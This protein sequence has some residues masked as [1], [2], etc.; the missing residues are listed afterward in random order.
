MSETAIRIVERPAVT[1]INTQ[2]SLMVIERRGVYN[3]MRPAIESSD[4]TFNVILLITLFA[5]NRDPISR[6]NIAAFA[7][8]APFLLFVH[9][10]AAIAFVQMFYVDSAAGASYGPLARR[11]WSSVPYFYG[12]IGVYGSAVALWWLFRPSDLPAEGLS[13]SGRKLRVQRARG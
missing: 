5:I 12:I 2:G 6:R 9:V 10:A 7:R 3:T 4:L 1:S 8:A 11:F 13:R